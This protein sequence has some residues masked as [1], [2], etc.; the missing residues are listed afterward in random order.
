MKKLHA[1]FVCLAACFALVFGADS[2]TITVDVSHPTNHFVPNQTLGAGVDRIAVEAIDKDFL[3]PTLEKTM[4]SGWQ[5]VTYRQNTELAVEAWHWNP[6][7]EHV[8]RF[9]M[10]AA[11]YIS[12]ARR[13]PRKPYATPMA[14]LCRAAVSPA[15]T[16]PIT[17]ASRDSPTEM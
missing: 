13:L 5:P 8:A 7:K 4:A 11:K 3:R 9:S 17:S 1:I 16:G 6:C 14:T 12:P 2:Q 15:T 10:A